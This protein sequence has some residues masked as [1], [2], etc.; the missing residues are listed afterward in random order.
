[1]DIELFLDMIQ[2]GGGVKSVNSI[3]KESQTEEELQKQLSI[4]H[5]EVQSSY[6]Y[7]S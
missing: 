2:G 5:F 7:S 3:V 1:M 6:F 4:E